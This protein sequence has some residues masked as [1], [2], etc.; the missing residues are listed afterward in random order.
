[1]RIFFH[2]PSFLFSLGQ[3]NSKK[4]TTSSLCW[5]DANI[6]LFF[7]L[8]CFSDRD[9]HQLQYHFL[10]DYHH[11]QSVTFRLWPAMVVVSSGPLMPYFPIKRERKRESSHDSSGTTP[12]S[13]SQSPID[14]GDIFYAIIGPCDRSTLS[15][16]S[17]SFFLSVL[18]LVSLSLLFTVRKLNSPISWP[19]TSVPKEN[20]FLDWLESVSIHWILIISLVQQHHRADPLT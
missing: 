9:R 12:L 19:A 10:K 20:Y 2:P 18:L 7:L 11:K 1:M 3:N 15:P 5:P 16:C 6:F 13:S 4:N 14:V 8:C 17:S